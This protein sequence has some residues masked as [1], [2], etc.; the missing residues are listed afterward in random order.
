MSEADR[1]ATDR[2]LRR[3]L[4]L[5]R[6]DLQRQELGVAA[7]GLRESV[8][9]ALRVGQFLLGLTRKGPVL[10]GLHWV[11]EH[12]L[13]GSVISIALARL[14]SL[15]ARRVLTVGL[16]RFGRLVL[17]GASAAAVGLA[18]VRWWRRSPKL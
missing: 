15:A 7:Q 18:A 8:E 1:S 12:P 11:R 13:A 5:L 2:Q 14:G 6:A 10:D 4:L 16:S 3:E 17:G 9:P